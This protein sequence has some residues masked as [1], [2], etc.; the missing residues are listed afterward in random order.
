[1]VSYE[2]LYKIEYF[3]RSSLNEGGKYFCLTWQCANER[4]FRDFS[5]YA[6]VSTQKRKEKV[7]PFEASADTYLFAL[8]SKSILTRMTYEVADKPVREWSA[9]FYAEF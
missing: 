1:M 4:V 2:Y 8:H 3:V 6:A 9:T 5:R 7:L